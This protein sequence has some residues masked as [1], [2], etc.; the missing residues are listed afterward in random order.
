MK[1]IQYT[2]YIS[3]VISTTASEIMSI[4]LVIHNFTLLYLIFY[5]DQ[6]KVIPTCTSP[7]TLS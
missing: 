1:G 5:I 2:C 7:F 6:Y 3:C 4:K